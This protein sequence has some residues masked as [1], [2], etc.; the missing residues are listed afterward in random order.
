MKALILKSI[1]VQTVS[2]VVSVCI[3]VG[4]ILFSVYQTYHCK[5]VIEKQG[6]VFQEALDSQLDTYLE[7]LKAEETIKTNYPKRNF[8]KFSLSWYTPVELKKPVEKLR[9]ATGSKPKEGR[10]IAVDPRVIP[11]GSTVYIEG[12]GY[13][14]A[15][16]TGGAIKGNRIDIFINDYNKAKQLGRKTANVWI[17]G[18]K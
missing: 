5:Q 1:R 2:T 7:V 14:I 4:L 15:E 9:T 13:F 3:S 11:Y 17:L 18:K 8:G 6:E 12:Y 10:T 16:D